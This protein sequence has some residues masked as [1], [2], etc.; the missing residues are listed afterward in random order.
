[1]KKIPENKETQTPPQKRAFIYCRTS[2]ESDKDD[3]ESV[4]IETQE[5]DG[6]ELA[7]RFGYS[8]LGIFKDSG[9]SGRLYP[10]GHDIPDKAVERYCDECKYSPNTRTRKEFGKLISRIN[11]IDV[12][13]VRNADR[14]MRPYTLSFLGNHIL[15]ILLDHNIVI[16]SH[17]DNII[18]PHK[19]DDLLIFDI[20]SGVASRYIVD[21]QNETKIGM[22]EQRDKGELYFP[23]NFYGFRSAGQ[24]LVKREEA[25]LNIVRRV[26]KEFLAGKKL[27]EIARDL[28]TENIK[29]LNPK[30]KHT[31][32]TPGWE[33]STIRSILRRPQYAGF[34]YKSNKVD[35]VVVNAYNPPAVD[36]KTFDAVQLILDDR[37]RRKINVGNTK[38]EHALK[39]LVY[40]GYCGHKLYTVGARKEWNG[41]IHKQDFFKCESFRKNR[42]RVECNGIQIRERGTTG[43]TYSTGKPISPGLEDCLFPLVYKAYIKHLQDKA[44]RVDLD[45]EIDVVKA[46]IERI[47]L[48]ISELNRQI[49]EKPSGQK[50]F[51]EMISQAIDIRLIEEK[52]L[53]DLQA[54]ANQ[55][56]RIDVPDDLFKDYASHNIPNSTKRELFQSVISRID[57]F[58]D[59]IVIQIKD[60]KC[61]TLKRIRYGK[62]FVLP[63]RRIMEI[64]GDSTREIP[65]VDEESGLKLTRIK[66]VKTDLREDTQIDVIYEY[67]NDDPLHL[68]YKD[69]NLEI[70]AEG[71]RKK[72]DSE[73]GVIFVDFEPVSDIK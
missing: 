70:F 71:I 16:H 30:R 27:N 5:A 58:R 20:K 43:M 59:H 3:G 13:I 8:V 1:M 32:H 15:S 45:N 54:K 42:N 69:D 35:E 11:E 17:D 40:C 14:L 65:Y 33:A 47:S 61:F 56:D 23:P 19:P 73:T 60:G 34:Q 44:R 51:K 24:R 31:T 48:R 55:E 29:T 2:S 46:K 38:E 67:D 50:S 41:E 39:P 26:F 12:I 52:K 6:L 64:N 68:V 37:N 18:D 49:L 25:E 22:K 36:R 7:K 63:N 28:N 72:P 62:T 21:R 53:E 10:T 9:R 66:Y 4:S 57:V